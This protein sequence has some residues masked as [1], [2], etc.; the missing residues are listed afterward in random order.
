MKRMVRL[1][2]LAALSPLFLQGQNDSI[3]LKCPLDEATVVTPSKNLIHYNDP[4]P[5]IVLVSIPDTTVKAVANGRVTNVLQNIV[6]DGK[7]EIVICCRF[8]NKEYYFW[9]SGLIKIIVKRNELMNAGQPMGFIRPGEKIELLMYD[10]ETPV[11]PA[12]Y[13][14]CRNINN[15]KQEEKVL[16]RR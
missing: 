6:E 10:Y 8:R 14:D 12:P 7:W 9:Y 4:D 3:R 16:T 11:N 15:R 5:C 2:I 1:N 13:L